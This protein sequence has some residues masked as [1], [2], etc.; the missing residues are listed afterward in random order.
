MKVQGPLSRIQDID[1]MGFHDT[2]L[3]VGILEKEVVYPRRKEHG[4]G[5][6]N[7]V[8]VEWQLGLS[9]RIKRMILFE[10]LKVWIPED[11]SVGGVGTIAWKLS[12]LSIS[13]FFVCGHNES[14]E[15]LVGEMNA[16]AGRQ[17]FG[18]CTGEGAAIAQKGHGGRGIGQ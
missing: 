11:I 10:K 14:I 16:H 13:I 3:R 17:D 18:C 7:V 2:A 6:T 9:M 1:R 4:P 8:F 12:C 15:N 5:R